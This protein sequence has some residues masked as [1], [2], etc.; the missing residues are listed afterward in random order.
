MIDFVCG[1]FGLSIRMACRTIPTFRATYYRRSRR[2]EQAL[3]RKRIRERAETHV[4]YGYRRITVLLQREGGHVN[5][6][7]VHRLYSLDC[8]QMRLTPPRRR[9][10]SSATTAAMRRDPTGSGRWIGCM[11]SCSMAD[12]CGFSRRHLG[13]VVRF[14]RGQPKRRKAL[15]D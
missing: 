12:G 13:R 7:R 4:R 3:L 15:L 1:A 5:V 10:P 14:V 6:K 9:V 2:P 8:L 11:M